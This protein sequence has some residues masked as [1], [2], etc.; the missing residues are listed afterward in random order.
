MLNV[1]GTICWF[2]WIPSQSSNIV[3]RFGILVIGLFVNA[4]LLVGIM[5]DPLK[6]FKNCSSY[7]IVNLSISDILTCTSGILIQYWRP[8]TKEFELYRLMYLP[9]YVSSVS[10]LAMAF[11]RYMS[12]VHPMKYRVL[13]TRKVTLYIIFL[14]WLISI[15]LLSLEIL[16]PNAFWVTYLRC[17]LGFVEIL[18]AAIMYGRAA[19]ILKRNSEYLRRLSGV[20]STSSNEEKKHVRLVSQKR[21]TTTMFL[22]SLL[23]IVTLTPNIIYESVSGEGYIIIDEHSDIQESDLVKDPY[24]VWLMTLIYVN[25][26]V[27]PF[28]YVWRLKNYRKTLIILLRRLGL[29]PA[30][31]E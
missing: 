18:T 16:F 22:V 21:L 31:S 24:H 1:T 25:F 20:S 30:R 29:C 3:P 13:I 11:D 23:T 10:I 28:V 4:L 7:L 15:G 14:Q 17:T 8:C 26:S 6:C 12:C 27:N 2:L 9:P 5:I 19:Y